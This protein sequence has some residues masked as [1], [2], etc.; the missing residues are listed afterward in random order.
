M[1]TG[2]IPADSFPGPLDLQATLESGQTFLWRR[3]SADTKTGWFRT[4]TD[5]DV[6]E[7]RERN[8]GLDWR[9]STDPTDTLY[10]RLDLDRDLSA[11]LDTFPDEPVI[12]AAAERFD[13]LRVVTEPVIPTLFSFILSAQMRIGRIHDLVTA[14]RQTY[15]TTFTWQ[16]GTVSAFPDVNRLADVSETAFRDLGLGYRAPYVKQTAAL[17]R[18]D[19]VDLDSVAAHPYEQAR[20][21]LTAFVGVGP[22]VADCV[23]LFAMDFEEPVPLDTWIQTA[24]EEYFPDADRGSYEA[25][26]R[27][28]RD[29]F[30]PRPGY[31]QTYV[32]THLRTGG[33]TE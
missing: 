27:A 32:F 16:G 15:G 19:G 18:D 31:T 11:I 14:L 30:G 9:S 23:L 4:V 24:I 17:L 2:H 21:E 22:K 10:H 26:S 20:S 25:T 3:V 1:E 6:I 33:S 8:G 13:G 7:V 5:S 12:Q 28:I 29:R